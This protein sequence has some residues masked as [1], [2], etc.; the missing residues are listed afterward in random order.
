MHGNAPEEPDVYYLVPNKYGP[1]TKTVVRRPR[2]PPSI[3]APLDDNFDAATTRGPM[4]ELDGPTHRLERI[5]SPS[6]GRNV[7]TITKKTTP[8]L[9]STSKHKPVTVVATT[10]PRRAD[11]SLAMGQDKGA[12]D[13]YE[14][15]GDYGRYINELERKFGESPDLTLSPTRNRK[16]MGGPN[17]HA[18]EVPENSS[19]AMNV[20]NSRIGL[21][22]RLGSVA[23]PGVAASA[24][25]PRARQS[26]EIVDRRVLE[27]GPERTVT[28]STWR[29]QVADEADDHANMDVYYLDEHAYAAEM[30]ETVHGDNEEADRDGDEATS[31]AGTDG[32]RV[33]RTRSLPP[34]PSQDDTGSDPGSIR[35]ITD[36]ASESMPASMR[37]KASPTTTHESSKR[38]RSPQRRS[39]GTSGSQPGVWHPTP[40]Q[41]PP[42][43]SRN[44]A[45][46][47]QRSLSPSPHH[48]YGPGSSGLGSKNSPARSTVTRSADHMRPYNH[49]TPRSS[50]P[51]RTY[52]RDSGPSFHPT[53]SGSTISTIKSASTIALESILES[54]EPSLLH[55][56]PALA[57]LGI[58]NDGHLR[59]IARLS[60]ETRDRELRDTALKQGITV[61][62]WA[63]LLDK[64]Q[65]L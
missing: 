56:A 39:S 19:N 59:A 3:S 57:R 48:T 32:P 34:T 51:N 14:V 23:R 22:T 27:D 47:I 35:T 42:R 24:A 6:P 43:P 16:D 28:I 55:V 58:L 26:F 31:V 25:G 41:T 52:G 49:P 54:C 4:T 60:G 46:D 10:T 65:E 1:N 40:P 13:S 7:A 63:I 15:Y 12:R 53:Q 36:E 30:E 50:T 44:P 37:R 20:G 8:P 38:S 61:M 9:P 29:E 5:R 11:H 21:P 62:E 33:S 64:L 18:F 45:L 2:P 17:G